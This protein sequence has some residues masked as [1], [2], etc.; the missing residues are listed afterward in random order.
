MTY[1]HNKLRSARRGFTLLELQVAI[2]LL[3]FGIVTLSSLL[4]TQTRLLKRVQGD[5]KS[6]STLY[7]TQSNDPWVRKM[8][9]AARVTK[10]PITQPAAPTVTAANNVTIVAQ[11][12]DLN[13]ESMIV[14]VDVSPI[15]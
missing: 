15:P 11:E 10:E 5:F 6:G 12:R 7:V 8:T 2:V 3:A 4:A 13:A 9:A 1:R 14:T